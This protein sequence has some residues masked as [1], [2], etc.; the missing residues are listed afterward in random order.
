[1]S[2]VIDNL[3]RIWTQ[4]FLKF[5]ISSISELSVSQN[6][7][8]NQITQNLL[9]LFIRNKANDV[10]GLQQNGGPQLPRPFV[11]HVHYA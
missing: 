7:L 3:L 8:Q 4:I 9:Y 5:I 11:N 1:M 2:Q 6:I 10:L